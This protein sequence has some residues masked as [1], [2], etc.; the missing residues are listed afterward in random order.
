LKLK[1]LSIIQYH[2]P[3]THVLGPASCSLRLEAMN[4][5]LAASGLRLEARNRRFP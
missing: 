3:A 4:F 5:W 2:Q 1:V